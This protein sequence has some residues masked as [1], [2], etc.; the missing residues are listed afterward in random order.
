MVN[1]FF[2]LIQNSDFYE[3]C[4][5]SAHSMSAFMYDSWVWNPMGVMMWE[6]KLLT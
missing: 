2:F 1:F 4:D 6:I 5:L 3:L